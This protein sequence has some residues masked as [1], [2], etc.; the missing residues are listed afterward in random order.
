LEQTAA[1]VD[2]EKESMAATMLELID[3]KQQLLEVI[4][5]R[6]HSLELLS[7]VQKL[8]MNQ[9]Q[10]QQQETGRELCWTHEELYPQ[11][12]TAAQDSKTSSRAQCLQFEIL[13]LNSRTKQEIEYIKREATEAANEERPLP[14]SWNI[15]VPLS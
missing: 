5:Q 11:I 7:K 6:D 9:Q 2:N 1:D 10:L 8:E 13:R 4:S 14:R 15:F 3:E 12:F